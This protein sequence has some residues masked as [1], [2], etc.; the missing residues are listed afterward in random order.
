M[1][2]LVIMLAASS[3]VFALSPDTAAAQGTARG[4]AMH[5]EAAMTPEA[6]NAQ[7]VLAA[8][9]Q[10]ARNGN[11][12]YSR[13]EPDILPAVKAAQPQVTAKLG[14][15]GDIVGLTYLGR[16]ALGPVRAH[17]FDAQHAK[18]R[19]QWRISLNRAGLISNID[20]RMD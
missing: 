8:L 2:K 19:S 20:Y 10:E 17:R 5:A 1:K 9:I 3:V 7:A 4:A 18:G 12:D 13:I 14:R 11:V 6:V 15:L 16:T